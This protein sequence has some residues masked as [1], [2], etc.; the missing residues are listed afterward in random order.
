MDR[1]RR[2][3][4]R[5]GLTVFG[6]IQGADPVFYPH[7]AHVPI[8]EKRRG[9]RPDFVSMAYRAQLS[10]SECHR[11]RYVRASL[12]R[13]WVGAVRAPK[14]QCASGRHAG[15]RPSGA[16]GQM[17]ALGEIWKMGAYGNSTHPLLVERHLRSLGPNPVGPCRA[18]ESLPRRRGPFPSS[19]AIVIPTESRAR[20][21]LKPPRQLR[22]GTRL[23]VSPMGVASDQ[24][25]RRPM[26]SGRLG[27]PVKFGRNPPYAVFAG[28]IADCMGVS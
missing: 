14:G 16:R 1:P 4:L 7:L 22:V 6:E 18:F 8:G 12:P 15:R 17:R 10:R 23:D 2:Y 25:A 11:G 21:S 20:I 3:L 5:D 19:I 13:G 26:F 9:L 28:C 24:R 27:W